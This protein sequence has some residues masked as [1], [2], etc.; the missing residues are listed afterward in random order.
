MTVKYVA[1]DGPDKSPPGTGLHDRVKLVMQSPT[2]PMQR[3]RLARSV[4]VC[5]KHG[6][7]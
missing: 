3:L 2:N 1:M 6:A 7:L 4:A 5:H